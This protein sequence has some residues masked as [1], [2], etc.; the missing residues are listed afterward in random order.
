MHRFL[1]AVVR[2][3]YDPGM[4]GNDW[5]RPARADNDGYAN[6]PNVIVVGAG[7]RAWRAAEYSEPRACL[8]VS[9][10]C[11][12]NGYQKLLTLD[13]RHN[14]LRSEFF[15]FIFRRLCGLLEWVV[16]RVF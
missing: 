5:V 15:N 3:D 1:D 14:R 10:P 7:S 6:N 11:G 4:G 9:A 12:G 8:L 2:N 13:E 16:A